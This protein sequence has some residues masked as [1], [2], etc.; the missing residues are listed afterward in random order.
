MVFRKSNPCIKENHV[1]PKEC[2]GLSVEALNHH[3]TIPIRGKLT[4][5]D[6]FQTL[7]GM[8]S[9]RKSIH[10]ITQTLSNVTC[11]TSLRYH[12]KKLS[13]DDLERASTAILAQSL[14]SVLVPGESYQFAIDYTHDPYYGDTCI[15]NE[16]YVIRSKRKRS[17]NDFYSYVTLY[18]I[19]KD[20]QVTLAVYPHRHGISKV[21]Y[22]ARCIDRISELGLTIEALC[23]DREFY[24]RRVIEFLQVVKI[25]FIMPVRKQGQ[26]L[27]DLLT[28]KKSRYT[29]YTMR[30]K[31][32]L[33]LTIAIVVKYQKGKCGK[34]GGVNL[35]YVVNDTSWSPFRV[36]QIYRSRFSIES[37]Y[38]MRNLAKPRTTSKDPVL[39][40]LYAIIS[41]LLKN[42]WVFLLWTRFSPVKQGPRTVS[43]RSFRFELFLLLIWDHI[44]STFKLV[45]KI[46]ALRCPI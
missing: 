1:K 15:A 27:K 14:S 23:L 16:D 13:M 8:A 18:A 2:C 39:R 25:P 22:I 44:R 30:G 21:G 34:H 36:H 20:R 7:V 26:R 19:T 31:P 46:P 33:Q 45:S 9:M 35:G 28:G 38:R 12:L 40:Y 24:T 29:T 42:V 17:T 32:A 41:F 6:I 43:M 3:L 37:S 4:Q 10:S 11:E 5:N